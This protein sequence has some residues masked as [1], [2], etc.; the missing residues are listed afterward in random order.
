[1]AALTLQSGDQWLVM[2][3]GKVESQED[4]EA[5]ALWRHRGEL[6]LP[7]C[8]RTLVIPDTA[9]DARCATLH[10]CLAFGQTSCASCNGNLMYSC[11]LQHAGMTASCR[12]A[13]FTNALCK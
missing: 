5:S 10:C 13:F 9:R 11:S 2:R 1:V 4:T 8:C 6:P 7:P 3:R 12:G